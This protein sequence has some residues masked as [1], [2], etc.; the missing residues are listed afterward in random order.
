[1][2]VEIWSDIACPWCYIGKRRFE[3][4]VAQLPHPVEVTWRSFELDPGA[5]AGRARSDRSY[6]ER[7]GA[8]YGKTVEEAQGMLDSMTATAATEGLD[9]HFERV[10][11]GN[12]F[13]AHRLLHLAADRGV[14]DALKERLVHA[15][16]TEG[17]PVDDHPTLVRLAVEAGLDRDEAAQV[18]TAGTFAD[19]VRADEAE[20]HALGITG[21]PFFVLDRRYGVSGAQSAEVL[22]NALREAWDSQSPLTLVDAGPSCDGDACAV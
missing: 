4:A 5:V 17:A 10:Q 14:Q 11:A 7:L 6:A 13:D 2:K 8:K 19:E 21:V 12:T 3:S 15:Y 18:L 16:F 1:M 22:L 9:F 20:A